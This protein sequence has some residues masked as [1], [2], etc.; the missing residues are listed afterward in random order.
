[1]GSAIQTA[2]INI[3]M[4]IAGRINAGLAVEILLS[5]VPVYNAELA[6]PKHRGVMV[7]LFAVMAS[8][9]VLCSNWVGYACFFAKGNAQ[10]RI[11]LACQIPFAVII[12][13]G[14]F[15]LPE[16]PRWCKLLLCPPLSEPSL[17]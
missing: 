13:L 6:T 16:S 3:G 11:G 12:C 10:W 4:L 17:T 14:A 5:V 8:F 1:V 7:G 9:G 15:I 2:A